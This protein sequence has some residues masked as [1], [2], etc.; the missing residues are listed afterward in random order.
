MAHE[1]KFAKIYI[2]D[3]ELSLGE[4]AGVLMRTV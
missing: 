4:M 2:V 3:V 1:D